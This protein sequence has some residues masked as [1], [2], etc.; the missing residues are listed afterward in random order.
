MV[1]P[2]DPGG[3]PRLEVKNGSFYEV[4]GVKPRGSDFFFGPIEFSPGG[5]RPL[6]APDGFADSLSGGSANPSAAR[7][8]TIPFGLI[9]RSRG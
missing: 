1:R 7:P 8:A 3:T 9:A 4:A 5:R 2:Q 6:R